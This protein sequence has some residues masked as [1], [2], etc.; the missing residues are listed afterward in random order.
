M[1]KHPI[2]WG[3]G[4]DTP[5]LYMLKKREL[6]FESYKPVELKRLSFLLLS[7]VRQIQSKL[8]L[9]KALRSM[10]SGDLGASA[11]FWLV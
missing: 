6:Y 10:W 5:S 7:T 9:N 11:E 2:Q 3:K 1:D 4:S 8:K